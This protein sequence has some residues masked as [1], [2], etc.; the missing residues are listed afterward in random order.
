MYS[1]KATHVI[2]AL[3]SRCTKF[4]F[5][6]INQQEAFDKVQTI[7]DN[8][9]L[10]LPS[11]II[12]EIIRVSKGDMR[13]C[14]NILQSVFL[15]LSWNLDQG[16]Q[17]DTFGNASQNLTVDKFYQIIGSISPS[18]IERIYQILLRDSFSTAR[19]G[20][21]SRNQNLVECFRRKC[22]FHFE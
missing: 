18:D 20:C 12:Q 11:A 8:E 13:K 10:V 22:W 7:C 9:K 5:S 4:K 14:I 6:S 16:V 15:A 1:N 17:S 3:Q 21:F 19:S 2:P